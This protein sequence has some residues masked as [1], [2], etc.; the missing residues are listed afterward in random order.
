MTI[1]TLIIASVVKKYSSRC[2]PVR[3]R[4]NTHLKL[5]KGRPLL[6]QSPVPAT[7]STRRRPPPYQATDRVCRF[8]VLRT[9]SAGLGRSFPLIRGRP[10]PE[11]SGGGSTKLALWENR[12]DWGYAAGNS[13]R[14]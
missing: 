7:T 6:Y 11:Y 13:P 5:T 9:T 10:L 14:S 12:L 1:V 3:S 8:S 4:T 2:V